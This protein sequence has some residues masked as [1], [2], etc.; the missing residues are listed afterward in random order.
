MRACGAPMMSTSH[1]E[2]PRLI[3]GGGRCHVE[4]LGAML[5]TL[6]IVG[7]ASG[8]SGMKGRAG[9]TPKGLAALSDSFGV[10]DST[11]R[12]VTG[13]ALEL[14]SGRTIKN[15]LLCVGAQGDTA[16]AVGYAADHRPVYRLR[17]W[18]VLD[19]SVDSALAGLSARLDL[20][21]GTGA[22]CRKAG[23]ER[24][25]TSTVGVLLLSVDRPDIPGLHASISLTDETE[26]PAC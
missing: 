25:W 24:Y 22:P 21:R 5:L 1:T 15:V 23:V 2:E 18:R 12:C 26:H 8:C 6:L 3:I 13:L 14:A 11:F 16:Y 9:A 10:A 20:E 17:T 7:A 4:R 19:S